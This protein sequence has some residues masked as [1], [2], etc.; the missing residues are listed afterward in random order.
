[1]EH[2]KTL[3]ERVDLSQLRWLEKKM[4]ELAEPTTLF[5]Y[6][7]GA[8]IIVYGLWINVI[9]WVLIG[10]IFLIIGPIALK[11]AIKNKPGQKQASGKKKK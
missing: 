10:G 7:L 2:Y 1:M 3:A 9:W 4:L 6:I 8:I 5:F 11:P